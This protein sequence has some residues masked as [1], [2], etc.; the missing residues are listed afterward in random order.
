LIAASVHTV[1][2][3]RLVRKV[4]PKCVKKYKPDPALKKEII[5]EL[6]DIPK[7]EWIDIAKI[8]SSMVLSE[9]E[10]C[11][12]CNNTGYKWR[13]WIYEVLT[14]DRDIEEL[15]IKWATEHKML[16]NA[17]SNWFVTLMQDWL[18][19]ALAWL[20]TVNEVFEI[21]ISE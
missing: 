15:V 2:A 1:Q 21:A 7:S 16:L 8:S 4:C 9:W 20:T 12:N 13:M 11:D 17:K 18:I 10:W 6:K 19:K 14:I 5:Q 3:Q